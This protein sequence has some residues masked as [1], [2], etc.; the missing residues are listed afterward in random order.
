[1]PRER[2]RDSSGDDPPSALG[3]RLA[4]S[5]N[6]APRADLETTWRDDIASWVRG[7]V[8]SELE[9]PPPMAPPI[10]A[11]VR[12][13]DITHLHPAVA[14]LY[15]AHLVGHDG[16]APYDLARVLGNRWDEALGRGDLAAS[17]VATYGQSRVRLST[18]VQRALDELP[19]ET[20]V[21]VGE[22][23]T[24]ALMG[25]CV[26]V[27]P[28]GPMEPIARALRAAVNGA[29]L[30]ASS[31]TDIIALFDE[32]QVYGAVPMVRTVHDLPGEPSIRVVADDEFAA[33]LGIPRLDYDPRNT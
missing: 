31:D 2:A 17:G 9:R 6:R 3:D 4:S 12:R 24:I 19:P 7:L 13:L 15:G 33:E 22:P 28:E 11:I 10:E 32:A 14:F 26:V 27:A 16:V 1:V 21:L 8:G 5:R 20:G 23:G 29:I 18:T 25:P 30:A